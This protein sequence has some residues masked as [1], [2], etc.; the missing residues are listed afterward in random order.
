MKEKYHVYSVSGG[1]DSTAMILRAVEEK[2]PID[3]I[4]FCDTGL[5]FPQMYRH[6]DKLDKWLRLNG[7]PSLTVIHA[8][9]SFEYYFKEHPIKRRTEKFVN[10][11]G[12][13]PKGYGFAGPKQ[14]WCTNRLKDQ[15]REGFMKQLREKYEIE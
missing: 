15:P 6:L 14:R 11:Y 8:P 2:K 1:K 9:H 4:L 13:Q 7:A 5:E 10:E 12:E 3:C